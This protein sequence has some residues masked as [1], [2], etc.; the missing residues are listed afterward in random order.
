M[1]ATH[2][3]TFESLQ[4]LCGDLPS[5]GGVQET[6]VTLTLVWPLSLESLSMAVCVV[7]LHLPREL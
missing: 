4:A 7:M 1:A 3:R 5:H 2:G 6:L